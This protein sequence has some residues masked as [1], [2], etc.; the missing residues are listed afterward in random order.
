LGSNT[1]TTTDPP[2]FGFDISPGGETGT[3]FVDFLVQDNAAN[4]PTSFGVTGTQG[5]ANNNLVLG[6]T[7]TLFSTTPWK[8]GQ[9][10]SYLGINA[11][12][13]N[14]IG[15]YILD[16][17][18]T[19]FYVFQVNLGTNNLGGPSNPTVGPLLS[20]TSSLPTDSYI[21]G[22][23]DIDGSYGATANSGAIYETGNPTVTTFATTPEPSSLLLLGTGT[24]AIAGA[25]RRR[26]H[27]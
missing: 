3:F 11:S 7:A 20:L 10:D 26:F 9:L 6:G 15:N 16:Q 1:P 2:S 27:N 19:G 21:L 12:P 13:S 14:P 24:L 22:F 25:L 4:I 5:G 8:T 23:L 17:G 18:S